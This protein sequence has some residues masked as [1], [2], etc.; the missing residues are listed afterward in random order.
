MGNAKSPSIANTGIGEYTSGEAR[1]A[2]LHEPCSLCFNL[3]FCCHCH[4]LGGSLVNACY[5][6]LQLLSLHGDDHGSILAHTIISS[7]FQSPVPP[8]IDVVTCAHPRSPLQLD[9]RFAVQA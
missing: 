4:S 2:F 5:F 8:L 6:L 1:C 7:A 3:S 9:G